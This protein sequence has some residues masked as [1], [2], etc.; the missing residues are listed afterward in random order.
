[1]LQFLGAVHEV[2]RIRL[3]HELA[4]VGLLH[5]V[6]IPLLVGEAD[7]VLLRVEVHAQAI[8]EV[9]AGLPPHQRVF[10]S[11]AARQRVPVHRPVVRVPVAGLCRSLCRTINPVE[12]LAGGKGPARCWNREGVFLSD[13]TVRAWRSVGAPERTAAGTD[14]PGSLP[15]ITR[16]GIGENELVPLI[17]IC[18]CKKGGIGWDS[19]GPIVDRYIVHRL[20]RNSLCGTLC[21]DHGRLSPRSLRRLVGARFWCR[22]IC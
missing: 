8:G 6:L 13:R 2:V 16:L 1:M 20:M 22:F 17:S 9:G 7:G 4:F 14:S 10:P 18:V 3:G 19:R 12:L 5:K 15:S 21:T 11:V